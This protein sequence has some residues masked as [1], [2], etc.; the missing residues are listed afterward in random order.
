VNYLTT[1]LLPLGTWGHLDLHVIAGTG[2][3]TVEVRLNG[4]LIYS[5]T[6]GTVPA[7]RTLQ[8]G[9]ETSAQPLGLYVDNV[10]ATIP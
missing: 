1:G 10:A 7:V 8:I 4:A 6:V 5:S 9:N 3:A 2:T